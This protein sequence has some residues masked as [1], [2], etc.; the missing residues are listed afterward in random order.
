MHS[1]EQDIPTF[2]EASLGKREKDR[3]L[4]VIVDAKSKDPDEIRLL[5]V[6]VTYLTSLLARRVEEKLSATPIGAQ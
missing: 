2:I 6:A 4:T 5:R 3:Y 1:I